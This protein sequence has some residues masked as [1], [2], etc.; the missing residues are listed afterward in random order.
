MR[1]LGLTEQRPQRIL[2]LGAGTGLLARMIAEAYPEARLTLLDAAPAM[3]AQARAALGAGADYVTADLI[4]PLPPGPWDAIVSALAIHHLEHP[5]KR[6]L[7]A[8]VHAA[9]R[10]GGAF[11]NAEH[12]AA[13]TAMLERA[14]DEWLRTEATCRGASPAALAAAHER[15]RYDRRVPVEEQLTWLREA[16]FAA[17]DC[18]FKDHGF[19]VLVALAGR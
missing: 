12:V 5:A 19:A 17:A 7:F 3:L 11:V 14:Y 10:P 8:R 9:L 6:A 2:D 13:P 16:G 4:D 18:L 1:A 15:M